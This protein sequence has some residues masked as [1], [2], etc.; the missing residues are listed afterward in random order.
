MTIIEFNCEE[1]ELRTA[2][3][4]RKLTGLSLNVGELPRLALEVT[5]LP[6]LSSSAHSPPCRADCPFSDTVQLELKLHLPSSTYPGS[7]V[8]CEYL[9]EGDAV[10]KGGST[11]RGWR[12]S[13]KQDAPWECAPKQWLLFYQSLKAS[14][15][16]RKKRFDIIAKIQSNGHWDNI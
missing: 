6:Q 2:K 16:S 7:G 15:I 4:L 12:R 13:R 1:A 10:K 14:A 9:S 11:E 8:A 3:S 5:K